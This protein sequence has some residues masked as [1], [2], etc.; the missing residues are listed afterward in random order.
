MT[1]LAPTSALIAAA[2]VL[3]LLVAMY[4][5]KLRRRP[6]RV[7]SIVLW[8]KFGSDVQV[9]VPLARPRASWLLLLHVLVAAALIAAVGRPAIPGAAGSSGRLLIVIDHSAS[10]NARDGVRGEE[11]VTRLE[12]AKDRALDAVRR[13]ASA[14]ASIGVVSF[15]ATAQVVRELSSDA[16]LAAQAIR[17][18]R[19]TDQPGDLRAA[20]EVVRAVLSSLPEI[21]SGGVE[22]LLFSDGVFEASGDEPPSVGMRLVRVGAA[23]GH[24]N[25]GLVALAARR[26]E[27]D[28]E[29]VEVFA[30]VQNAAREPRV[31]PVSL[32]LSG[33]AV[34]SRS[35]TVPSASADGPGE[36]A[37]TFV[38]RPNGREVA[39]VSL[40]VDEARDLLASDNSASLVV[41]GFRPPRVLLVSRGATAEAASDGP[42]RWAGLLLRD[43]LEELRLGELR[44]VSIG[45]YEELVTTNQMRFVDAV[46]FEDVTP[47]E[48]PSVPSLSINAGVPELRLAAAA[49]DGS[50]T[51]RP[52]LSWVRSHPLLQFITL[53]G[54]VVSRSRAVMGAAEGFVPIARGESGP[55]ILVRD[56]PDEP[57]RLVLTFDLADSN[58]A[59]EP[60]FAIFLNAAVAWMTSTGSGDAAVAW[61]TT[62]P[63][64]VEVAGSV[65]GAADV[66]LERIGRDPDEPRVRARAAGGRAALGVLERAGVYVG[67]ADSGDTAVDPV[68][69]NLLNALESGVGSSDTIV[70]GNRSVAGAAASAGVLEVWWWFLLGALLLLVVEWLVFARSASR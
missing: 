19:A 49:G 4:L 42:V 3:P 44:R 39:T 64:T 51:G 8:E 1:F 58:W 55:L 9:N 27:S 60:G 11:R 65:S 37:V 48:S 61:T 69:V 24:E 29:A 68:A 10:M 31:T 5:L 14:S 47:R 50:E 7:S 34:E 30:R 46:I 15:A 41:R 40:G 21:D 13:A 52:V 26:I 62:E 53:D 54:V 32:S 38:C 45:A 67:A 59:V 33:R 36:A 43:V 28:R 70:V 66:E 23:G 2:V 25:L 20:A 22:V 12:E 35:V 17:G 16:A 57:R 18:V 6:L 63:V 56:T